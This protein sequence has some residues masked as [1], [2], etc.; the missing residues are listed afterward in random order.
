MGEKLPVT[1][2]IFVI[3]YQN[4][5]FLLMFVQNHKFFVLKASE[6]VWKLE[7]INRHK[8]YFRRNLDQL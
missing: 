3:S 2:R 1:G 7:V 5:E 4:Y 8:K 6:I